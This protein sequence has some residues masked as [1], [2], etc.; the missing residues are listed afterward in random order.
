MNLLFNRRAHVFGEQ[1]LLFEGFPFCDRTRRRLDR[2]LPERACRN[3]C[4]VGKMPHLASRDFGEAA[5]AAGLT[6]ASLEEAFL[7]M[8]YGS[9]VT[10]LYAVLKKN[11]AQ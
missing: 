4:G 10:G 1:I 5:A 6:V 11:G 7:R 2:N 3:S 8:E 9:P